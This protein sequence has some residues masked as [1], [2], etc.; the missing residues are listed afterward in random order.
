MQILCTPGGS[1]ALL[2]MPDNKIISILSV[3]CTTIEPR[4]YTQEI[5]EQSLDG[6]SCP[7]K[8]SN[9]K[10]VVSNENKYKIEYFIAGPEKDADMKASAALTLSIH[11]KFKGVFTGISCFKATFCGWKKKEPNLTRHITYTLHKPF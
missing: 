5:K 8:T 7:N 11:N 6:K 2:G 3:K 4:R 9:D 1:T 10:P